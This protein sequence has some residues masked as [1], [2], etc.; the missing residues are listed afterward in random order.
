MPNA[1]VEDGLIGRV[2]PKAGLPPSPEMALGRITAC[3]DG[4]RSDGSDLHHVSTAAA[5]L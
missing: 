4:A 1:A 3:Q 2:V 5:V